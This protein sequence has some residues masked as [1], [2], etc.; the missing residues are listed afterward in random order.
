MTNGIAPFICSIML[1]SHWLVTFFCWLL[2]SGDTG[3]QCDCDF[4]CLHLSARL[5]PQRNKQN[6]PSS[7]VCI[8]IQSRCNTYNLQRLRWKDYI[9]SQAK[10]RDIKEQAS[11]TIVHSREPWEKSKCPLQPMLGRAA[12]W[13]T[14]T[15]PPATCLH[16]RL[17]WVCLLQAGPQ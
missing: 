3:K 1:R 4:N 10:S 13:C 7:D 15:Q 12:H 17:R 11:I 5:K 16:S 8:F 2:I 14:H 9:W 6:P